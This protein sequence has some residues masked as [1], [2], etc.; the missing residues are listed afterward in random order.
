[1]VA[2]DPRGGSN[3]YKCNYD[4]FKKWSPKMAYVLGFLYADG[5]VTNTALSSRTQYVKFTNT[6]RDIIEKIRR[7]LG[8][9]H[10]IQI[11]PPQVISYRNGKFLNREV[12]ALRIGSREMFNDLLNLGVTPNKSK[13]I[14]FPL[15]PKEHLSHFVRG[16]LDGDGCIYTKYE[17]GKTRG[18][19][20]VIF[21]SGSKRYLEEL[22]NT[23]SKAF[24]IKGGSIYTG[25]HAFNLVYSTQSGIK[26][27]ERIYKKKGNLFLERKYNKFH[28]YIENR[29][30][31][32]KTVTLSRM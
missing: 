32:T 10:T 20:R 6:E 18:R 3:R 2:I 5:D 15:V 22:K 29:Q 31:L 17:E 19:I 25:N 30:E 14:T 8:S 12:F 28:K 7:V 21:T 9:E 11:R 1:M 27:L 16:Y 23:L 13:T 26:I 4:F 24:D